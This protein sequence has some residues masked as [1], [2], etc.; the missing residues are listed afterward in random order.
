MKF[1]TLRATNAKYNNKLNNKQQHLRRMKDMMI[2]IKINK[3]KSKIPNFMNVLETR[4]TKI[5]GPNKNNIAHYY[6]LMFILY[7][8]VAFLWFT[9]HGSMLK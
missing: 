7:F 4:T 9:I 3:Y 1:H 6:R 2:T 5:R 8:F